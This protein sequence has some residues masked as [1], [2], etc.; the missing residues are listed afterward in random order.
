MTT[1]AA[2]IGPRISVMSTSSESGLRATRIEVAAIVVDDEELP[3]VASMRRNMVMPASNW[4]SGRGTTESVRR[5]DARADG[6]AGDVPVVT[7]PS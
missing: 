2:V 6:H 4:R 7:L 5:Y 1:S 3:S